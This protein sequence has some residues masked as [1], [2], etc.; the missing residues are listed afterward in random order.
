MEIGNNSYWEVWKILATQN[1]IICYREEWE[2]WGILVVQLNGPNTI[3][4]HLI[5]RSP[6]V[7]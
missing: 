3:Q 1:K 2:G 7:Q 5:L 6:V 4:K